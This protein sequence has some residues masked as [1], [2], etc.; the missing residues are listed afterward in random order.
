MNSRIIR[1]AGKVTQ[2]RFPSLIVTI[3]I[4]AGV[5]G[6]LPLLALADV[7]LQTLDFEIEGLDLDSGTV[8]DVTD[9]VASVSADIKIAYNAD[10]T[11]HAVV[12]PATEG[13]ELA[14]VEGTAFD[15][16]NAAEVA[17]FAFSAEPVDL[18]FS[19]NDCV[20]L[21]TDQGAVYKIGNATE[22]GTSVTFNYAP[23]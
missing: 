23:L 4:A 21:R 18:P 19:P 9:M 20:V 7:S 16:V 15:G 14:F 12:F 22:S 2:Y 5:V 6:S 10:R 13:V 3:A 17:G 11:L 1:R 8:V